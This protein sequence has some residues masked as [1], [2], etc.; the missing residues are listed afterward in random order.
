[1]L[2]GNAELNKKFQPTIFRFRPSCLGNGKEAIGNIFRT[3]SLRRSLCFEVLHLPCKLISWRPKSDQPK[4]GARGSPIPHSDEI[5]H[6]K[7]PNPAKRS[8]DTPKAMT[9]RNM[10]QG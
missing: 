4:S 5:L 7:S 9:V 10:G 3:Y 8:G 1:M 6:V 2:V